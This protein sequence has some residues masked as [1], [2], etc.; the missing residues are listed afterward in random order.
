M[1]KVAIVGTV[2]LPACYGGFE[3]LVENLTYNVSSNISYTVFCS[4]KSYDVRKTEH[5]KASLEYLPL[6]ANGTQSIP[7]DIL[8]LMKCWV[9]KPD[10][11]LILGVSGCMFLP[12]YKLFSNSKVVT[13]IDGLEWKREK[14]HP[15]IQKF[16]KFSEKIAVNYSDV[17]VCDNQAIGDYVTSEYNT[18]NT[19]IAY[20]GD[21]VIPENSVPVEKENFYFSVCRI[22]PENNVEMILEAFC[23]TGKQLKF[24]GNWDVNDFGKQLKLK[25]RQSPN[26]EIIDPIY[27]VDELYK[28]RQACKGYLHGHSAGGTNPSLV[29]A[30]QFG[31]P[32]LAF[33]CNFN[34]YSTEDQALYFSSSESLIAILEKD[35]T[36]S[37][38]GVGSIMLEIAKRK[39]TWKSITK[40]YE[41]IY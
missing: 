40:A 9:I 18:N 23:K 11:T 19:V 8:S 1:K 28:L 27:D 6:S 4:S 37:F 22:E 26:I 20:G 34:R 39:Y 38:I 13:N 3:T 2:G 30:M 31:M 24:V 33:D 17:V 14:W 21:H 16:L 35:D 7:Y 32:I 15:L 12:I 25:Y 10:I 41:G 5:N 36:S 29:E